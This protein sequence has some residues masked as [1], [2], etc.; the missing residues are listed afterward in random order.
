M[1]VYWILLVV[2]LVA[3]V[4][5]AMYDDRFSQGWQTFL[6]IV[7]VTAS[8]FLFFNALLGDDPVVRNNDGQSSSTLSLQALAGSPGRQSVW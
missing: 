6:A 1:F 2:V 5:L 4:V 7:I 8:M 3:S